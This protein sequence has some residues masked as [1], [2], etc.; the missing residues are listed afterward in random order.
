MDKKLKT[1]EGGR[2]FTG[3]VWGSFAVDGRR[4]FQAWVRV[5][6]RGDSLSTNRG[7]FAPTWRFRSFE[8][9]RPGEEL[10]PTMGRSKKLDSLLPPP[11]IAEP[12]SLL[13]RGVIE[14]QTPPSSL[15]DMETQVLPPPCATN[16][17]PPSLFDL[18]L[19]LRLKMM[20]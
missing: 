14:T 4:G 11:K 7:R 8:F 9:S 18:S 6:R 19:L 5:G 13:P 2:C 12:N 16:L 17:G 20:K 15:F 3:W 10:A 1:L